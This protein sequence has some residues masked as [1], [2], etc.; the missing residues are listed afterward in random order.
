ML[1][2]EANMDAPRERWNTEHRYAIPI[3]PYDVCAIP[4]ARNTILFTTISEPTMP[5]AIETKIP[6]IIAF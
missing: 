3:P 5:D 2:V 4:P 1:I 6:A